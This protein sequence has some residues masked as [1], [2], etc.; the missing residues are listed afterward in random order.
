MPIPMMLL[1]FFQL[2]SFFEAGPLLM[3]RML[4]PF[5]LC[6]SS[7]SVFFVIGHP[8]ISTQGENWILMVER[9]LG[10]FLCS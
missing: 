1:P 4:T 2:L 10:S 8:P 5:F 6:E 9:S 7:F 3:I